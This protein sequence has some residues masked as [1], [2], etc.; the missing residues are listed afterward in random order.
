MSSSLRAPRHHMIFRFQ[1]KQ[2][3]K[4]KSLT[5]YISD[6]RFRSLQNNSRQTAEMSAV[7]HTFCRRSRS[8][9]PA[10][11][12]HR[13]PG[14]FSFICL[15]ELWPMILFLQASSTS[16][17]LIKSSWQSSKGRCLLTLAFEQQAWMYSY[18]GAPKTS[19]YI[20]EINREYCVCCHSITCH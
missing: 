11:E 7:C 17:G 15:S 10:R 18:L 20:E 16:L 12:F 13:F 19:R 4:L 14:N 6:S 9:G 8:Q 5:K 3:I 2:P 1:T